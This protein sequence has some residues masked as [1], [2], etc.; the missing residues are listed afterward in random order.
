MYNRSV[1]TRMRLMDRNGHA[2][3]Q[4]LKGGVLEQRY[5]TSL[6]ASGGQHYAIPAV[7]IGV[8]DDFKLEFTGTFSPN[9]FWL[10]ADR[11]ATTTTNARI[12]VASNRNVLIGSNSLGVIPADSYASMTDGKVRTLC[13]EKAS[14]SLKILLGSVL[15]V[16]SAFAGLLLNINAIGR[17]N[18]ASS[19]FPDFNGYLA[20]TKISINGNLI[21]H[22]PL[23]DSGVTNVARELVSGADGARVNLTQVSTKL[24]TKEGNTWVSGST[25]LE[26]AA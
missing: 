17:R 3:N 13:I 7:T 12:A 14:N 2:L 18:N 16:D 1:N 22:Y 19:G 5:L 26:I 8:S 25:V 20:D 23:D 4:F 15:I 21:R 10:M 11:F 24:F 6:L 9:G